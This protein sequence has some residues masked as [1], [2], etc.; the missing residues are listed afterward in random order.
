MK[1][2]ISE[3]DEIADL[4]SK[5]WGSFLLFT[6]TFFP[7]VTGRKFLIS[8]PVGRESHFITI[9]R[10]L[11]L[12]ARMQSPSVLINVPPGYGKSVLLSMWVAWT[13]SRYPDSQYLYISYAKALAAKHT[14]FVRDIVMCRQYGDIF[15]IHIKHDVRG[16]EKF[17]VKQGGMVSAFGAS[18]AVT[19]QDAGMPGE[20]RFTGAVIIDD[21]HKP[22]EVHSDTMRQTVIDN[23]RETILQRPRDINV[24]VIFI[25]QRL[26]EDDL[27]AF[28]L[29][30]K[31]ERTYKPI[32]LQSIDVAGNAL[33]PEVSPIGLLREKQDK[34]PYV[35]SSQFQQEPV[36][37][38]GALFKEDYFLMLDDEP[39]I[40]STFITADTAETDKT[41]NDATVFSF[42]GVYKIVEGG[43]ETGAYALHWL[44]C[45]EVRVEPKDLETEFRSFYSDCMLHSVKPLHAAIEKKS[46]GVTLCSV[47]SNMRGLNIIEVKRTRASGSKAVRYLE[48]QPILSARLVTLTRGAKHAEKCVKHMLKITANDTHR[49]DDIADTLYDACKIAL[50]DKTTGLLGINQTDTAND[51]ILDKLSNRLSTTLAARKRIQ[52]H[53]IS[54]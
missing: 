22:D 33:Y 2:T 15:G 18:G 10:E 25:G 34:N 3:A 29:S 53:G 21:P 47:L 30:G 52:N 27:A 49:W 45:L 35:F 1:K 20:S 23:Y 6:Q 26:H 48:M 4:R 13:M 38:G 7:L 31:D 41:Y 5:L 12:A 14:A 16:R 44:D 36:P 37:S 28:M 17:Q 39:E 50:I 11:T 19:G 54:S 46:T 43:Q 51:A 32:I 24:P 9:A 42:W 8:Q 40:I